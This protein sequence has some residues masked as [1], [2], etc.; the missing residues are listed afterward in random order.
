MLSRGNGS[1]HV[2]STTLLPPHAAA[3]GGGII[4]RAVMNA[5]T[6]DVA[7]S[8]SVVAVA[9]RTSMSA[10]LASRCA[11]ALRGSRASRTRSLMSVS[12]SGSA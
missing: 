5:A 12:T 2:V 10:I 8:F 6:S 4:W 3:T 11:L 7:C 9:Q 1:L